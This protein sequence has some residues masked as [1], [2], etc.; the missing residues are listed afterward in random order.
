MKK[1]YDLTNPL[2]WYSPKTAMAPEVRFFEIRGLVKQGIITNGISTSLHAGTHIDAPRHFGYKMTLDEMPLEQ[3]CGTG[4]ILDLKRDAWGVITAEDLANASPRIEE[5]DRVVLNMG[6]H[7]Y[8]DDEQKFMLQYPGLDKSAV[9]WLVEKKV[10]W[11]GSDTPSPDHSFCISGEKRNYRPDVWTD[12][13]MA[14]IDRKRFLPFYCHRT[15]L[16]NNIF[17][18]EQLGGQIDEVTGKRVTLIVLPPKYKMAE[19]G[20]VRAIAVTD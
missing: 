11:V 5:G 1:Y 15:L 7:H 18:V 19:A 10:S 13:V 6:W 12:E 16:K 9:D 17:M 20:Q 4:V 3:L 14:R 2:W 8:F